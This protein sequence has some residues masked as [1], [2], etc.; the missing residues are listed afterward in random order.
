MLSK[1][2]IEKLEECHVVA[3][4]SNNIGSPIVVDN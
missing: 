3:K 2:H 4:Y 1:V